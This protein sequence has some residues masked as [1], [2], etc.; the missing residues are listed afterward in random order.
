MPSQDTIARFII[1][2]NALEG[3]VV[4][5]GDALYDA[6]LGAVH[7][8]C[9]NADRP[10]V[11]PSPRHVHELLFTH[12]WP[13]HAGQL[14]DVPLVI[15]GA[16]T[17]GV[18]ATE[19]PRYTA[20]ARLFSQFNREAQRVMSKGRQL[21]TTRRSELIRGLHLY[22]LCIHPFVDGNG[23]TFRLYENVLRYRLGLPWLVPDASPDGR[24]RYYAEIERFEIGFK[25]RHHDSYETC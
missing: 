10:H 19:L 3:E 2:T 12:C 20:V 17:A 25:K 7:L 1:A 5:A 24:S 23:R 13:E 21:T 6:H 16:G 8:L 11:A 18:T 14:R 15:R 4:T 9:H 22:G